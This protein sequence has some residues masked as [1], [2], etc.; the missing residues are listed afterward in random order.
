MVA[1]LA[2]ATAVGVAVFFGSRLVAQQPQQPPQYQQ[3]PAAAPMRTR[4]ALVNLPHVIKSYTKYQAFEHEWQEQYKDFDKKFEGKRS[5]MGQYQTELQK[6]NL[7]QPT[8]EKYEGYVR[9]LQREMQDM[10]EEAKKQLGKKRDEQAVII[11]KEIEEAVQAFARSNDIELVL[12]F[13]DAIVP[14]DLYSP[15]NVQ[16][17]LQIGACMPMYHHPQM[18]ITAQVISMLNQHY[19]SMSNQ[20]QVQPAAATAPQPNR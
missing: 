11:Y 3:P 20:G 8:R 15:M 19:A 9:Q 12:H 2:G 10:G 14:A 16:R 13:N 1:I 6:P 5:L 4:I 17:K 7:D 18:D